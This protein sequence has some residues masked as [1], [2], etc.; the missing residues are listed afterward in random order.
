MFAADAVAGVQ[1]AT[2]VGP[3]VLV[4]QVIKPPE[5]QVP[6]ATGAQSSVLASHLMDCEVLWLTL[7]VEAVICEVLCLT[8]NVLT[9]SCE[10]LSRS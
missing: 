3:V 10:L 8:C 1:L 6:G 2:R 9:L 5:T 4:W 7:L